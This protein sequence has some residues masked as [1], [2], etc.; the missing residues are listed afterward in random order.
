[1]QLAKKHSPIESDVSIEQGF[2]GYIA[3]FNDLI[4]RRWGDAVTPAKT[5]DKS[6]DDVFMEHE[7][8]EEELRIIPDVK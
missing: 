4:K 7:D 6:D 1:M 2:I 5:D 8:D 3:I